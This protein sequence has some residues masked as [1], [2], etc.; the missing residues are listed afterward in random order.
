MIESTDSS[1]SLFVS[2]QHILVPVVK[3]HFNFSV[4]LSL[5]IMRVVMLFFCLEGNFIVRLLIAN[6]F[7]ILPVRPYALL[8]C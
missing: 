7:V 5:A 4:S 6:G 3:E 8:G 1:P 2:V